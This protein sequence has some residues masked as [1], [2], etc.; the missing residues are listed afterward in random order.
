MSLFGFVDFI[1]SNPGSILFD[2]SD[3]QNDDADVARLSDSSS[4]SSPEPSTD[5]LLHNV[6]LLFSVFVIYNYK[7]VNYFSFYSN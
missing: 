2:D 1:S 4:D 6:W 7:E 5:S 3:D